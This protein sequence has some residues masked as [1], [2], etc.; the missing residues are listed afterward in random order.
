MMDPTALQAIVAAAVAEALAATRTAA[1]T[2]G[3]DKAGSVHKYYTRVEK[4]SSEDWKEWHYQFSVATHAYSSKN[5]ALLE[6]I[7]QKEVDEVTTANLELELTQS[8]ADWMHKTKSEL[9]SVLTLLTKGE[10]NQLVRSCEDLNGYTAWNLRPLQPEN[11]GESHC[12]MA[13][14]NPT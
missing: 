12:S 7:E 14:C 2:G 8:E 6:I 9:F 3:G 11:P 10:A 13:G 1:L 5:G 4:F